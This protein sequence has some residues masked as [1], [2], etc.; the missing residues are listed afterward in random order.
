M[1]AVTKNMQG[2]V[3]FQRGQPDEALRTLLAAHSDLSSLY[4]PEDPTTC[5]LSLNV[6][7]ALERQGRGK[8][9]L[10]VVERAEPTLRKAMGSDAPTYLRAKELRGRL[11]RAAASA[12]RT[13]GDNQAPIEFFT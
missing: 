10:A 2:I 4:G 12:Q 9:A 3:Y 1:G 8:E 13:E 11:E 5:L 7:I 6:A